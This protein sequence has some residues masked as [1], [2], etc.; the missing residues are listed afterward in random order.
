MTSSNRVLDVMHRKQV[1]DSHVGDTLLGGAIGH[2]VSVDLQRQ[3]DGT[4]LR[5]G[6][7]CE[8]RYRDSFVERIDG[9]DVTPADS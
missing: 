5:T 8:V 7:R 2:N 3:L 9:Y 1:R 6:E 4:P